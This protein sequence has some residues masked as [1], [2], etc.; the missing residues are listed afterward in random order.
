MLDSSW[1]R[2]AIAAAEAAPSPCV[3]R[4]EVDDCWPLDDDEVLP[5]DDASP[6]ADGE[7][8]VVGVV[9]IATTGVLADGCSEVAKLVMLLGADVALGVEVVVLVLEVADAADVVAVDTADV[10]AAATGDTCVAMS[11]SEPP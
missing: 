7:L 9:E 1:A 5:P 10:I 2:A 8:D 6:G 11:A 3:P 4:C